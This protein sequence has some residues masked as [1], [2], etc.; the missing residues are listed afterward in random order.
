MVLYDRL[1]NMHDFECEFF[2]YVL[3]ISYTP[4][5]QLL[6]TR[7]CFTNAGI[8]TI[9]IYKAGKNASIISSYL[10]EISHR[11]FFQTIVGKS[12]LEFS[13]FLTILLHRIAR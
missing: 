9:I 2:N 11:W 7:V 8:F 13:C 4:F 10:D 5:T 1:Q 3:E 6:P 12:I